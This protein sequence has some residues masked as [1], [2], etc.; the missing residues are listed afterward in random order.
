[1]NTKCLGNFY[2]VLSKKQVLRD[3]M[4]IY[5]VIAFNRLLKNISKCNFLIVSEFT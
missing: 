3:F 1:M 4:L 5:G 2:F